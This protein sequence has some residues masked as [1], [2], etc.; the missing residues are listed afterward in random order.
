MNQAIFT[1]IESTIASNLETAS[2][3]IK[4]AVAWF[5][6]PSLLNLL[7]D[8][9][10]KGVHVEL[11]LAND[12]A[13][14]NKKYVNFQKLIDLGGSLRVSR[15]P[16][17]MHHKY[18][19]IDNRLLITG[20]YNWTINAEQ[21]NRENIILSTDLNL[22]YAFEKEF[23]RLIEETDE[24]K[25]IKKIEFREYGKDWDKEENNLEINWTRIESES[26]PKEANDLDEDRNALVEELLDLYDK[27]E[28]LYFQ[29]QYEDAL[30]LANRILQQAPNFPDT[31]ELISSIYWRK[32]NY[33]KQ[34][35]FA[36]KAI[37][38]DNLSYD[39]YNMLGIGYA[40]KR[41]A[42]KS[43][44]NYEIC[45]HAEPNNY[46]YYWN[47]GLSYSDLVNDNAFPAK[48]KPQYKR[49]AED[50]FKKVIELANQ[51][52]SQHATNYRLFECRGSA[53]FEL[54]RM[55]SA[56]QDLQKALLLYQNTPK[57][58]QDIHVFREIQ[59]RL[60]VI[61]KLKNY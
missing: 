53:K 13:N 39:A 16:T 24:V 22:V 27:A 18:C 26:N 61:E 32:K 2:N 25:N 56:K 49:K 54:D 37:E 41:N 58:E 12:V 33:T 5:T 7:L 47:R 29:A 30:N 50:D 4:I 45:I 40:G 55:V 44:E 60:K 1:K 6:N 3:H 14:F 35:E 21:K 57:S 48:L 28:A 36:T 11:I 43:I 38:L 51:L 9:Q 52:E 8:K 15:Y 34:I 10:T 59:G 42:S 17:L 46:I 31:Y 23:L 19:L 20:S